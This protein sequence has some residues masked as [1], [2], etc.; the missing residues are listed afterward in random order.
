VVL[1]ASILDLSQST[2]SRWIQLFE[3]SL[4]VPLFEPYTPQT[5]DKAERFIQIALQRMGLRRRRPDV[6]AGP[7]AMPAS[8]QLAQ[9]PC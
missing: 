7:P 4:G 3:R 6:T 9:A 5:Y 1:T 8:Q 2:V